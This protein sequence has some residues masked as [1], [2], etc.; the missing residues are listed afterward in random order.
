M[1]FEHKLRDVYRTGYVLNTG[2]TEEHVKWFV[3]HTTPKTHHLT[4]PHFRYGKRWLAA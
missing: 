3:A 4:Y 1:N 2:R